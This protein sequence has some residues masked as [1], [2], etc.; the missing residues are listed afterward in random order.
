MSE[1][2]ELARSLH[3]CC[4]RVV[5]HMEQLIKANREIADLRAENAR[6]SAELA[7]AREVIAI[8]QDPHGSHALA[9]DIREGELNHGGHYGP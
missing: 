6:L 7:R 8:A 2:Q 3:A 5:D 1:V 4:G 9:R